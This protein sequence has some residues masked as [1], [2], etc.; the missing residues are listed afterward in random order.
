MAQCE[1]QYPY[2]VANDQRE[3]EQNDIQYLCADPLT[4][5]SQLDSRGAY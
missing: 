3:E 1:Y 5:S 4:E 2:Q